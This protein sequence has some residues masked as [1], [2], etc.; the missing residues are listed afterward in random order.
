M[1]DTKNPLA[2]IIVGS[3]FLVTVN[4]GIIVLA[5]VPITVPQTIVNLTANATNF[6][7]VTSGGILAVNTSGFPSDC[8]PISKVVCSPTSIT[9]ITDSRPD[10]IIPS[11]GGG[12]GSTT[13]SFGSINIPITNP[14][15]PKAYAINTAAG[16]VDLYTVPTGRM[17]LAVDMIV[18]NPTGAGG[19]LSCLSEVKVSGVY[20]TFDF[21]CTVLAAGSFGRSQSMAPFLL[22]AGETLAVNANRLGGSVWASV[23]EFD[24]TANI[25]DA[26]LFSLS[27]G[28]NTLF[29]VPVGKTVQ[30]VGFPS[31]LNLPQSGFIW[32]WNNSGGIRTVTMNA[33]PSGGSVTVNNEIQSS[34]SSPQQMIQQQFY[35]GLA[36]GDFINVST[37]ASTATQV[38]WVIYTT[39]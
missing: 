12:S 13:L 39:Q 7:H 37:D 17:A 31:A 18:T 5:G 24:A 29:T 3:G 6:I 27:A 28:T 2:T 20:H 25:S 30:F 11:S 9:G 10:F 38:A 26:R 4:S 35:G 34:T 16:D 23:I 32:Y 33:V 19:T 15:Y 21:I 22:R 1:F 14:L 36:P 8:L